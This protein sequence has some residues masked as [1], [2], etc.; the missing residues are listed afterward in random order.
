MKIQNAYPDGFPLSLGVDVAKA[1]LDCALL[2]ND[3]KYRNK[4]VANTAKGFADLSGWVTKQHATEPLHVCMEATSIYWEDIAQ[5]LAEAGHT[6]AVVN[7][8]LIKAYGQP[9]SLRNKTDAADARLLAS[10]CRERRPEAWQPYTASE[11]ILRALALRRQALVDMQ[12]QEKNRLGVARN[13]V[14]DSLNE[15]LAW[16]ESEIKRIEKLINQHIDS[17]PE[18]REKS[19]LLR[20]IPGVAAHTSA[21]LLSYLGRMRQCEKASAFAVFAGLTPRR[22]ESGTI[23]GKSTLSKKGH[24]F[25]RRALYMPAMNAISKTAWGMAFRARLKANGK[26]GKVIIG[27]MMRKIAQVAFA[28]IKSGTPFNPH[29]HPA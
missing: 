17:D 12:T 6:V 5:Y 10:F 15:H 9:L 29:L 14:T 20:S 18:L 8:A 19:I 2:R 24:A 7:P 22:H 11:K 28:I 16:L 3:G 21:V 4:T 1:K 23:K 26:P 27:A 13:N 25:L